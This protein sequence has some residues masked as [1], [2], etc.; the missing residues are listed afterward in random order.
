[1]DFK[2]SNVKNKKYSVTSPNGKTINFG[3][4]R[5]TQ[6]KDNALGLYKSQNNNDEERRKRYKARASK[7]KD[8]SGN[9]TFKN[10]EF[11]NYYSYKYLW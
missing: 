5:Y 3:D 11:A 1:M 8:K 6:F 4:K 9:L 2:K 7:I 10:P